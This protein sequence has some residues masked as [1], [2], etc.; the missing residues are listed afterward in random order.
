MY[1]HEE[2]QTLRTRFKSFV[3][4]CL[5]VFKI[6]KK[7]TREEFMTISKVAGLGMLIIGLLGFLVH[8]VKVL[9]FK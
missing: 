9:V 1:E 8:L 6:T 4:E 2:K 7:P 3:R 5:R